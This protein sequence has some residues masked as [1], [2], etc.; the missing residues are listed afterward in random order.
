MSDVA[1]KDP[2]RQRAYALEWLKRN[3]QKARDAVA[4]W[5]A[6]NPELNRQRRRQY[7]RAAYL[8]DGLS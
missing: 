3:P 6:R 1:Y 5:R 7:R 8:R 2:E 4:R